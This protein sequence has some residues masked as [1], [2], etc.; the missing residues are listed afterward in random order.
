MGVG[1]SFPL[2]SEA[3]R[4]KG[5][6]LTERATV[7][8]S[9]ARKRN[10]LPYLPEEIIFIILSRCPAEFLY[11]SARCVCKTWAN[12]ICNRDFTRVQALH[13]TRSF[14]FIPY[15]Y[16]GYENP[17][18][19]NPWLLTLSKGV[20]NQ[21]DFKLHFPGLMLASSF[22]IALFYRESRG[23]A[24]FRGESYGCNLYVVNEL[25]KQMVELPGSHVEVRAF[26]F[27]QS[28]IAYI[29]G[30][31]EIKVITTGRDMKGEFQWYILTV[32]SEMSWRVIDSTSIP[33]HHLRRF[34][35]Y[36]LPTNS[37]GGVIYWQ[38]SLYNP[39]VVVTDLCEETI[40][41]FSLRHLSSVRYSR[42]LEMGTHLSWIEHQMHSRCEEVW[43]VKVKDLHQIDERAKLY[44]NTPNFD[45]IFHPRPIGWLDDQQ[46]LVYTGYTLSTDTDLPTPFL[47]G[48][49]IAYNVSTG[50]KIY[51]SRAD[52]SPHNVL[53]MHTSSL[54]SW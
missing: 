36:G 16:E 54:I 12:I 8:S 23:I 32:G 10:K 53:K 51:Q 7:L 4:A 27:S 3:A 33:K 37:V 31:G 18:R 46:I 15:N 17:R 19:N 25:T 49:V 26:Y 40:H 50:M 30:T 22:G 24:I 2:L 43:I 48:T 11:R 28:S 5:K 45:G 20:L 9:R 47:V 52:P 38:Y 35:R 29:S 13:A 21:T 14:L 1:C 39:S 42:L 34:V 41:C 6:K 44:T